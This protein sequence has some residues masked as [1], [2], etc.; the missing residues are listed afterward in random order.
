MQL[1]L[2]MQVCVLLNE[3]RWRSL[4]ILLGKLVVNKDAY[5]K[6]TTTQ[7]FVSQSLLIC[8]HIK[9]EKRKKKKKKMV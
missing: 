1:D 2:V 7:V 9:K 8:K 3:R 6:A 5:F 4:F